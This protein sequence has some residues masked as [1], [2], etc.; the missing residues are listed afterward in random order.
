V[1]L[2]SLIFR[3][4]KSLYGGFEDDDR[5]WFVASAVNDLSPTDYE[6]QWEEVQAW[7]C[8]NFDPAQWKA[9]DGEW[10]VIENDTLASAFRLKWC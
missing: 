1:V 9:V 4:V 5:H 7:C 3:A 8:D 2:M 10:I 6:D